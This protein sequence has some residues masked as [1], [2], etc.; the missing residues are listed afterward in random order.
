MQD[1]YGRLVSHEDFPGRLQ[2][3]Y[4]G[5]TFCPDVCPDLAGRE[6]PVALTL[7]GDQAEQVQPIF[8]T[9]DPQRDTLN[10]CANT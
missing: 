6:W 7:L 2:P 8:I 4:F 10:C 5:Y 3:I 9:V 1:Q